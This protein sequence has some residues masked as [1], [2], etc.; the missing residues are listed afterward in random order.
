MTFTRIRE[1]K[2]HSYLYLEER[3]REGGKVRSRS[4]YLGSVLALIFGGIDSLVEVIGNNVR[5]SEPGGRVIDLMAEEYPS[6]RAPKAPEASREVTPVEKPV[7]DIDY[8]KKEAPP[9]VEAKGDETSQPSSETGQSSA[10][11]S[12]ASEGGQSQS[13]Q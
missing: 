9:A 3:Y 1:I 12:S 10:S 11:D 4:T 2:G 8:G 5:V 6:E 13:G 7:T